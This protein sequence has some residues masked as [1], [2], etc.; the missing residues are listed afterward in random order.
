MKILHML[1]DGPDELS[2]KVIGVQSKDHQVKVI[3][4]SKKQMTYE[5]IIDEIFASDKVISW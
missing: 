4:L 3:D 2:S 5:A 1:N